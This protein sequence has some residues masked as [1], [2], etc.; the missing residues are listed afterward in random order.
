MFRL[1]N[2]GGSCAG[3]GAAG[4]RRIPAVAIGP[5]R[6]IKNAGRGRIVYGGAYFFAPATILRH[7]S[8]VSAAG[9]EPLGMR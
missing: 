9:S 1:R 4:S 2:P 6:Y 3:R 7:S 8:K 5:R